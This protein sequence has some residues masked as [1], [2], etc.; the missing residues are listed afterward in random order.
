MKVLNWWKL[1]LILLTALALFFPARG[2]FII[3]YT[4]A[5][6]YWGAGRLLKYAF[7]RVEVTRSAQRTRLF[8]GDLGEI[9][10]TFRNPTWIPVAWLSGYE[11]LP[12]ALESGRAKRWV[13]SLGPLASAA[14]S[15]S[16]TGSQ[17]GV[18]TV[19]P[20]DISAGEPLG[21][22]QFSRTIRTSHDI[23]VYPRIYSLPELGLPSKLPYGNI[24]TKQPIFPDP[25]RITGVRGYQPGDSRQSIHWKLSARTGELQVKLFQHTVAV[26]T[27]L[28]LNLN[29]ADYPV[30]DLYTASELAI[31]T[32]ASLASHLVRAGESVGLISNAGLVKEM[33]VE[34]SA[35]DGGIED[36]G[37]AEEAASWG[38]TIRL[39]PRKG[40]AQLMQILESLA[41]AECRPGIAFPQLLAN[42][43]RNLAWGTTLLVVTP[44]DSPELVDN[45][46]AL[47]P[48]GYQV[49][50]FVVGR[51]VVHPQLLY[52]STQEN[53]QLFH[54]VRR[55]SGELELS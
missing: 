13:I 42:E 33:A 11:H 46:L 10:L 21:L 45:A 28:F 14:A 38:P 5:V 31:E 36:Q 18:Y 12:V 1:Y 23:V 6:I 24:P 2:I 53:L 39:L 3:F 41:A 7:E 32:A 49:L 27:V 55:S 19:G 50:V 54:I 9:S 47:L 16:I 17:R 20:L 40:T 48:L 22:Y 26:D 29:E 52:R 51:K 30:Q 34:A 15:Y 44:V 43:A 35:A 37:A 4:L 25:A 8:P